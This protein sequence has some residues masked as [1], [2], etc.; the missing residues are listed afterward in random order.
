MAV[1]SLVRLRGCQTS[2]PT[3]LC[4]KPP[5]PP[6]TTT[7]THTCGCLRPGLNQSAM[8]PQPWL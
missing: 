3:G 2:M 1:A 8:N 5:S 6:T 7:H 4:L